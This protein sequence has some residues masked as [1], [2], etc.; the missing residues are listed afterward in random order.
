MG[1]SQFE[2]LPLKFLMHFKDGA[3]SCLRPVLMD[4]LYP[5]SNVSKLKVVREA[6]ELSLQKGVPPATEFES[7]T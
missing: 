4:G 6:A 5:Q 7:G 2:V 1:T 3:T